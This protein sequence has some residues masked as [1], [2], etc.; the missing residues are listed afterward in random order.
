MDKLEDRIN[1][2]RGSL[3]SLISDLESLNRVYR[4]IESNRPL[5]MPVLNSRRRNVERQMVVDQG[6]HQ[7]YALRNLGAD[8]LPVVV[9]AGLAEQFEAAFGPHVEAFPRDW[10]GADPAIL[11]HLTRSK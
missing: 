6:R 5:G 1:H 11:P 8:E 4:D 7:L 3:S 10:L 9:P 2:D